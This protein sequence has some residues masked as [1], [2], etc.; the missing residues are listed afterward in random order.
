MHGCAGPGVVDRSWAT[1]LNANGFAAFRV[2]SFAGRGLGSVC[3]DAFRLTPIERIP[4][5]YGA[6]EALA[7][8]PRI[9]R[10]RVVLMGF[11]HGGL[12]TLGAS[13][14][15]AR[16]RYGAPGVP[17]F[18]GFV[19]F[20]PFCNFVFPE[21]LRLAAP[22]RIHVGEVDDW[23][24]TASCA[25]LVRDLKSNGQSAELTV[26]KG[27]HHGFDAVGVPQTTLRDVDNPAAC[28][29]RA[30]S[31]LGPLADPASLAGCMR[32]G[33][34]IGWDAEATA[35]ARRIV[36]DQLGALFAVTR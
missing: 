19:A 4:D 1:A 11:S 31:I 25:A 26:Y 28:A 35:E 2:D 33:A 18:R 30:P 5:A 23:T 3:T 17:P 14:A 7:G 8:Q 9:D 24:P 22:L 21:R 13:T 10:G 12:L 15:W 29:L 36:L 32:K 20:Y 6:L 27:A 16:E 34:T